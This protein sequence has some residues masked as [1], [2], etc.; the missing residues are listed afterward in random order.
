MYHGGGRFYCL[1]GYVRFARCTI[2]THLKSAGLAD[3]TV[4]RRI[5]WAHLES[6]CSA[7]PNDRSAD[8]MGA[9][10][11]FPVSLSMPFSLVPLRFL[12]IPIYFY[13]PLYLY[14]YKPLYK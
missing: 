5:W 13:L 2:G 11:A 3:R 14:L 10:Q 12:S 4:V 1:G 7:G 8:Q 9:A 6:A